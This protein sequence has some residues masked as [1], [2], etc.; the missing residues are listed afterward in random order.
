M[1]P[2]FAN[3]ARHQLDRRHFRLDSHHSIGKWRCP[4]RH[5]RNGWSMGFTTIELRSNQEISRLLARSA[6]VQAIGNTPL[7][8]LSR[9]E[10]EAGLPEDVEIWLKAEW[11][12]P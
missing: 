6:V 5:Q 3:D 8:R 11:T 7:M 9:I 12:N 2:A 4:I 1:T 10:R